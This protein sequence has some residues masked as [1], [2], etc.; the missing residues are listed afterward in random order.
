MDSVRSLDEARLL[1]GKIAKLV[2]RLVMILDRRS[3]K[4]HPI[5]LVNNVVT[6]FLGADIADGRQLFVNE[7]SAELDAKGIE[8]R[9]GVFAGVVVRFA[10]RSNVQ[11]AA[12]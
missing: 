5:R 11:N 12:H 8:G 10:G 9:E 1:S 7:T 3:Q 2:D 6:E 4:S